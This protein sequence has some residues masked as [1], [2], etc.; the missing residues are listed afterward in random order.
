MTRFG[1]VDVD[2]T[3]ACIIRTAVDQ[4]GG[5][6]WVTMGI[7]MA[8]SG[9]DPDAVGDAGCS[10]GLL[11][12]NT[13]GGQGSDYADNKDALK[14]PR[15]NMQV[16]QPAI[17]RAVLY[18]TQQ[19]WTGERFIREVARRS[20]HPGMVALDDYRLNNIYNDTVQ[21]ITDAEGRLAAWPA[22][23]PRLC[24]GAPAPPPPLGSWSEGPAP[25]DVDE[26]FTA[27]ERHAQ[28]ID[29]L[30]GIFG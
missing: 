20:G 16:G 13:C 22:N 7:V 11:Q 3:I 15:L 10:I 27:I 21:L 26:A 18:A 19:G 17:A 23:D 12:L 4:I 8:E 28:R 5:F 6:A 25:Q 29:E 24:S 2:S 30:A 9:F 1:Q 14:D